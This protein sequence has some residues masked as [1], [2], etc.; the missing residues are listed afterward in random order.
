MS[1]R[2]RNTV[3]SVASDSKT[4]SKA[5]QQLERGIRPSP[6]DGRPT[7]SSGTAC[8]DGLLAGHA[9][10]P[11]GTSLLVEEQ[12]TTDFS[13]VLLKYYAAEGLVQ[14]HH[15]H[16]L[17]YG[18][19]WKQELPAVSTARGPESSG[20]APVPAPEEDKLKIAWRYEALGNRIA[21]KTPARR[22]Y[23]PFL[24]NTSV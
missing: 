9:G 2:K 22:S 4:P 20:K 15:V 12:G 11:L 19:A 21:D 16:V 14:G 24:V 1:F 5:E 10:I 17:G 7:T 8:L 13:G 3:L 23:S 6:R 18:D